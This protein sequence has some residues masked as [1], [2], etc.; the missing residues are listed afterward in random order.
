MTEKVLVRFTDRLDRDLYLEAQE[1]QSVSSLLAFYHIPVD[2]V[3]VYSQGQIIDDSK[4]R[5]THRNSIVIQMVR[6]YQLI[7]F[8]MGLQLWPEE[9]GPIKESKLL[10]IK[11][12]IYTKRLLFFDEKG[13][14]KLA[15][16]NISREDYPGFLENN[17]IQSIQ[18][19]KLVE[20][21]DKVGL[22]LSGGRDSL[23]LLYLLARAR[24]KLP[25]FQ[26]EGVT[27]CE[28]ASP[29]EVDIANEASRFLQIEHK[30][31]SVEDVKRMFN[32]KTSMEEALKKVLQR[33]GQ[34]EAI[35]CAHAYMR[36]CVE[37]YFAAR[38]I[39]K[40]AFGLHNEDLLAALIR[41][42]VSGIS[43]GE[44]FYKKKWGAFEFIYPLW[45]IAKK[46]LTI[47]LEIIAPPQHSFQ[48]SPPDFDRGG[49]NR[50]IQ[51][52]IAD[53]LQT[54]WP[55]FSYFGFEGYQKLM[56]MTNEKV[57]HCRCSHCQGT[58]YNIDSNEN[59]GKTKEDDKGLCHLC[60]LLF[61]TGQIRL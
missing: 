40:I 54:L 9:T 39:Y 56:A 31:L 12:P 41:S 1:G 32:L 58:F 60:E 14:A 57:V 24:E 26:L 29:L 18:E 43:F 50:D 4:A 46:E 47:Y 30:L 53:F 25:H 15:V 36:T 34:T 37:R 7:D 6:A 2:A 49:H 22:A 52:F 42:I 23:A 10:T 38:G 19:K 51:Y 13:Q 44:S 45:G 17:F 8:L 55:G 48:G 20:E 21:G 33:Y 3:V 27:I 35:S 5:I 11:P 59:G 61:E 16:D 28:S